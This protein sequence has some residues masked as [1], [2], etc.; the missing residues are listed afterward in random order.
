MYLQ[1]A[2]EPYVPDSDAYFSLSGNVLSR[3]KTTARNRADNILKDDSRLLCGRHE[4]V[5]MTPMMPAVQRSCTEGT[6]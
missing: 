6:F 5:N 4:I 3:Q 1:G 2:N